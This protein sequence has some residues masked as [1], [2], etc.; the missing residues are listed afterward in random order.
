MEIFEKQFLLI[1][2]M[3]EKPEDFEALSLLLADFC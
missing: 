1:L 3:S 2:A